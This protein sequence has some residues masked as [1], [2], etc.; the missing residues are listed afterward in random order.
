MGTA[1]MDPQFVLDFYQACLTVL[2]WLLAAF[3]CL[4]V[5]ATVMFLWWERTTPSNRPASP[6]IRH[7][8]ELGVRG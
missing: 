2:V 5:F 1:W 8:S 4:T 3:A 6:P 7:P